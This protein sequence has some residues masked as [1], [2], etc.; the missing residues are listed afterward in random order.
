LWA[1][2]ITCAII[3]VKQERAH[4]E[5]LETIRIHGISMA[6]NEGPAPQI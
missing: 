6:A 3:K 5:E 4:R 2:V 1:V